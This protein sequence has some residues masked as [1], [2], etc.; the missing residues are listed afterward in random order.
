MRTATPE[1]AQALDALARQIRQRTATDEQVTQPI[2]PLTI[3]EV[4]DL[5]WQELAGKAG[6]R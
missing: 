2:P 5:W 6:S 4:T 3:A 1:E